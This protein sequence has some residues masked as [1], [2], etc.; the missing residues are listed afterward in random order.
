MYLNKHTADATL[1][2]IERSMMQAVSGEDGILLY[3][4]HGHGIYFNVIIEMLP[5]E[6]A[7]MD[8]I[9]IWQCLN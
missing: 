4:Q 1:N 7:A 2:P 5:R 8:M 6:R 9:A 3:R